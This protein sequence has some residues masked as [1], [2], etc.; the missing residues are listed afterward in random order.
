MKNIRRVVRL[1]DDYLEQTMIVALTS[2]LILCLT[3]SAFIRYFVTLP[4]F[5]SLTHK[6]EELAIFAF[7][8]LL[9]WG[10]CLATKEKAHF[11]IY[12]H[13]SRL[14]ES[15]QRWKYLP[16]DLIWL[17]FNVFIVWQGW[18]LTR[19]AIDNP[20]YSLSL[21]VPMAI[22]YSIIPLTFLVTIIRMIQ[23]Y[24]HAEDHHAKDPSRVPEGH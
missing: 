11:R 4:F 3:Y 13:F 8:W 10:A 14:P 7:I 9:Y 1:L 12:A 17:G 19:S 22:V 2:T 20:E 5:T 24:L 23:N 21:E 18:K 6:A 15:W 16:G